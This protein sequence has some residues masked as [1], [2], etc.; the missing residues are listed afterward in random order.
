MV[1]P[2]VAFL[3]TIALKYPMKTA[4]TV[5][6]ALAQIGEFSFILSEEAMKYHLV[7]DDDYDVIVACALVSISINPLLFRFLKGNRVKNS[8]NI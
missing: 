3:I 1:K 4:M 2:L 8:V 7:P 5:S 6:L